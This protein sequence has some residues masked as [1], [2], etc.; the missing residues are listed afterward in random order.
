M[1]KY[2]ILIS[3][4]LFAAMASVAHADTKSLAM[5]KQCFFCH[6]VD[7]QVGKA[8]SFKAIAEKYRGKANVEEN[9]A[10][11]IENGGVDHWG[12]IPMPLPEGHRPDVS[13]AEAKEL[14]AWILSQH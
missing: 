14:V 10:Q 6:A 13:N 8:P 9:L 4:L 1:T 2:T 7:K 12:S 11:R 5:E 3:A